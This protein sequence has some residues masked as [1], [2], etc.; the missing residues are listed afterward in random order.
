MPES[1]T[2]R[3]FADYA[4]LTDLNG[5]E[6]I[7]RQSS[8]ATDE[9]VWIFWHETDQTRAAGYSKGSP[10]LNVEMARRVVAALNEFIGEHQ[11]AP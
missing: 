4:T 5:G 10:H 6:V 11:T 1:Y 9:A 8:L 2:A 3:G 7:V